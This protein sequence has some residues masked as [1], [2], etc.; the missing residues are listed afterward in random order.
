MAIKPQRTGRRERS[1]MVTSRSA[2]RAEKRGV[3]WCGRRR[4]P[5]RNPLRRIAHLEDRIAR[6]VDARHRVAIEAHFL[7]QRARESLHHVA[8]D[9]RAQ[10]LRADHQA[11]VVRHPEVSRP[12]AAARAIDLDLHHYRYRSA[13]ALG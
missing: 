5:P 6:P 2:M 13:V 8:L 12:D 1:A 4:R 11:A 10:D 7:E 3:F 9:S